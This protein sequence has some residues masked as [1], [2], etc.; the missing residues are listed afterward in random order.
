MGTGPLQNPCC[1][2]LNLT[3]LAQWLFFPTSCGV[4]SKPPYPES[5][6][7]PSEQARFRR[8]TVP[9]ESRAAW[10]PLRWA[11]GTHLP[12][13]WYLRALHMVATKK[14]SQGEQV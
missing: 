8:L 14:T 7:Q 12:S 13:L 6:V 4:H 11:L 2:P 9:S 3:S 1:T 10:P 5:G